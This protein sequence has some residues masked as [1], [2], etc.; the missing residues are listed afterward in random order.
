MT[1]RITMPQAELLK[2]LKKAGTNGVFKSRKNTAAEMLV[3]DK[4]AKWEQRYHNGT[5]KLVITED[6]ENFGK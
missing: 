4:L 3:S 5:G 6:G 2:E 1:V